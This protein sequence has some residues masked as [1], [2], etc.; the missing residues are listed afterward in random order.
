MG[1]SDIESAYDVIGTPTIFIIAKNGMITFSHLGH[2]TLEELESEVYN[3]SEFYNA[4]L[5]YEEDESSLPSV[6]MIPALISIGFIA[7]YRR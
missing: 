6:S 5:K 4:T 1:D 2:L 3:A 7:R